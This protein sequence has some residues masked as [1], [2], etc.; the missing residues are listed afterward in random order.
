MAGNRETPKVKRVIYLV[1][2]EPLRVNHT[3]KGDSRTEAGCK[4]AGTEYKSEEAQLSCRAV[5]PVQD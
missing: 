1:V 2:A 4:A 3:K 5:L